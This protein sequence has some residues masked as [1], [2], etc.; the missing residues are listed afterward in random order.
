LNPAF[1]LLISAAL[2]ASTAVAESAAPTPATETPPAAAVAEPGVP[3]TPRSA[4]DAK[5]KQLEGLTV[6][7]KPP[8]TNACSS[9][10][11]ACIAMVVAELKQLYPE[12]LKKFCFQRKIQAMRSSALWDQLFASGD[13]PTPTA[14]GVNSA[15]TTACAPDKK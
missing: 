6:T 10:D 8:P 12:Q 14:F 1:G 15:L 2:F 11:Q 4:P 13:G 3:P 5:G 9:R 7:G